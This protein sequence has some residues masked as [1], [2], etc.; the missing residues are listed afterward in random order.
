MRNNFLPLI[1]AAASLSAPTG[2][3]AQ[4]MARMHTAPTAQPA[5]LTHVAAK[6]MSAE[7]TLQ[8]ET[9]AVHP[10]PA[11]ALRAN[12]TLRQEPAADAETLIYQDF[13]LMTEGSEEELG[14]DVVPYYSEGDP[15][16]PV[17][18]TGQEG[19]YGMGLYSAGG[20]VALAYPG[21][22]GT[23]NTPAR[24][25]Y[26]RL[27]ITTRLKVR[28][29]NNQ[30]FFFINC[31]KGSW[32]SPQPVNNFAMG[33]TGSAQNMYYQNLEDGWVE[34]TTVIYN[35]YAGDDSWVQVNA[36]TYMPTGV[37]IDEIK[38]QRDYDLCTAP[39]NLISYDFTNEGFTT[40][41]DPGVNNDSYLLSVLEERKTGED[42]TTT[43]TFDNISV[44]NDGTIDDATLPEGFEIWLGVDGNQAT[45]DGGADG[46]AALILNS[47]EDIVLVPNIERPITGGSVY[48]KSK[49]VEG[50]YAMLYIIG[51]EG[52]YSGIA[53][54]IEFSKLT[55]GTTINL[56]DYV[57]DLSAYTCIGFQPYYMQPGEEIILDNLTW[58]TLGQ[59]VTT[60]VYDDMPVNSNVVPLTGLDPMCEYSFSV[61]GVSASGLISDATPFQL[62]IGCPAPV[63]LPAT[64]IDLSG[65]YTANWEPSVKAE[66]YLLRNF[67]LTTVEEDQDDYTVLYDAFSDAWDPTGIT[68]IDGESFD[69]LADMNGWTSTYG[70]YSEFSIGTM[71]NG[72][73]AAPPLNLSYDGG[74]F[75]VKVAAQIVS[76]SGIVI[77]CNTTSYKAVIAPESED[78]EVTMDYY[79]FEVEFND[80]TPM[81]Q[82][83]FYSY[84]GNGFLLEEVEV[85]QNVKAGD[86][87]I[88]MLGSMQAEGHDADTLTVTDLNPDF[89]YAYTVSAKASYKGMPYMSMPSNLV[90]V[91]MSTGIEQICNG[92]S[93]TVT[94]K[95]YM[96]Y[97]DCPEETAISVYTTDGLTV[98]SK[99]AESGTSTLLL[100]AAGVYIVKIGNEVHKV[101]IY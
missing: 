68:L 5:P 91:D 69:G 65:A 67:A 24:E 84:D 77:Q 96:L 22:G 56:N 38:V 34:I 7:K 62:A 101:M 59:T 18:Y 87:E 26:G 46:T 16:I 37:L 49:V 54:A 97:I 42:V 41:W 73:I 32:L 30:V 9:F 60:M 100:P 20:S 12:E 95:G 89:K 40:R 1:M 45:T 90:E 11:K 82:L 48:L 23:I 3:M 15:Y 39:T 52:Y 76:G 94:T 81:T 79:E 29:G 44:D 99:V 66:S 64:D 80:G 92:N 98:A 21:L 19:W 57:A 88:T 86:K 83:I 25:M 13:S 58:T 74:H 28:E 53:G 35:T 93:S 27:T 14:P 78:G 72:E 4:S 8:L 2:I 75:K 47:N 36:V 10:N 33:Q 43:E 50:S 31:V 6:N 70:F 55:E 51:M 63:A 71:Y 85:L 17:E 61:K